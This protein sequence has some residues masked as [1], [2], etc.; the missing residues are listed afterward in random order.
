MAPKTPPSH[1]LTG[2]GAIKKEAKKR[3][4]KQTPSAWR[5][6]RQARPASVKKRG[7]EEEGGEGGKEKVTSLDPGTGSAVRAAWF[8]T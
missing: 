1:G 2:L 5:S 7:E 6:R 3:A 8:P 4:P